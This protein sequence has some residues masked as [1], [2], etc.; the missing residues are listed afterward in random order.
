MQFFFYTHCHCHW[1][2][3]TKKLKFFLLLYN[4]FPKLIFLTLPLKCQCHEIFGLYF[5]CSKNSTEAPN[6]RCFFVFAT[7]FDTPKYFF[8]LIIPLKSVRNLQSG[9]NV[10]ALSLHWC[11]RSHWLRRHRSRIVND[12]ADILSAWSMT[13]SARV[14]TYSTTQCHAIFENF[15]LICCYFYW[16]FFMFYFSVCPRSRSLR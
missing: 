5:F 16:Y 14:Y 4:K 8:R 13:I 7:I 10:S 15:K 9:L 12:F 1:G 2:V 6:N 3:S 11:L